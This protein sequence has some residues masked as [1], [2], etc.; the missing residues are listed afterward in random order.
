MANITYGTDCDQQFRVYSNTSTG[1]YVTT[2]S[3]E[4]IGEITEYCYLVVASS[5]NTTAA[6]RGEFV[7]VQTFHPAPGSGDGTR[8]NIVA[9][10][11]P[12]VVMT[13]SV[14]VS[15]LITAV[16]GWHWYIQTVNYTFEIAIKNDY[17]SLIQALEVFQV[18]K[19]Y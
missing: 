6:V 3:L 11:I 13:L 14:I 2:P 10:I 15:V 18:I 12:T 16:Y 17:E 8:I 19:L 9:I 7:F 1:D 4:L 5:G